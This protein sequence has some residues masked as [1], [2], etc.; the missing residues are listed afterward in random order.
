MARVAA[1]LQTRFPEDLEDDADEGN[2]ERRANH[3]LPLPSVTA[4]C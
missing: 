4:G 1:G 2:A 3:L